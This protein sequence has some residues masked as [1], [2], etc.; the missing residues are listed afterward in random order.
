MILAI[1]QSSSLL[2]A[3]LFAARLLRRQSASTR[4]AVLTIGLI[5]SLLVPFLPNPVPQVDFSRRRGL[6]AR[7]QDQKEMFWTLDAGVKP[8]PTVGL[9]EDSSS[10]TLPFFWIWLAGTSIAGIVL[11]AGTVRIAWLVFQAKAVVQAEWVAACHDTANLMRL[12]RRIR[13]LHNDG[14]VLGTCGL[15]RPKVFLP[16]GADAW[17]SERIYAVLTHELAHIKRFDWPVQLLAEVARA[18][19]WFN[20][21]FWIACRWLRSESEHACDDVVLNSGVDAKDYAAHLLELARGQ[22]SS[23]R[24]WSPV[25]AMSRPPNLERR[26]VAMLNPSLNHRAVSRRSVFAICVLAVC[27]T[28]PLAAMRAPAQ[29]KAA[30]P[31]P[32]TTAAP[33]VLPERTLAVV[34]TPVPARRASTPAKPAPATPQGRADGSLVGTVSDSSGA[35]VPRVNVTVASLEATPTGMRETA[36]ATNVSDEIGAFAFPALTP[37]QYSLKAELPGFATFR[38]AGIEIIRSQTTRQNILLSV[39]NIVQRVEVSAAGQPRPPVPQALPQRIRVGGN[40]IAAKL[41]SQVKPIYPQSAREAGIEGLVQMQGIIGPEGNFIS[42]RVVKSNDKDL[43][44]AALEAVKQWRYQPTLL[45]GEPIEV[46][47]EIQVEFKLA[48]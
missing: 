12:K 23:G 46:Q 35:V 4:H 16:H 45:N 14:A 29:S 43:S 8:A 27:M 38:K 28:L 13:L 6:Y 30:A 17:P 37:G 3:A 26:F 34:A 42:L 18:V 21:L 39:G 11:P 1:I 25:L 20:P 15:L 10:R 9:T 22:K 31:A 36:I 24:S 33:A 5:G 7:V 47:T 2:S 32:K 19:Y 48:Q 44:S 41:V 40:I